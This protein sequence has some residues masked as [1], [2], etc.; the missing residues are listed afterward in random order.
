MAFTGFSTKQA[1]SLIATH[2]LFGDPLA[3]L[4][5]LFHAS[6]HVPEIPSIGVMQHRLE[7]GLFAGFVCQLMAHFTQKPLGVA[8]HCILEAIGERFP[9]LGNIPW[10]K[11]AALSGSCTERKIKIAVSS[12]KLEIKL[13]A[14][15]DGTNTRSVTKVILRLSHLLMNS[16][17]GYFACS[18]ISGL[19][20]GAAIVRL[21]F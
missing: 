1:K 11:D 18:L 2:Q 13:H 9:S 17:L 21:C 4:D 19:Y 15:Q 7:F 6:L 8:V 16:E 20:N 3:T 5:L 14:H 10:E 12:L